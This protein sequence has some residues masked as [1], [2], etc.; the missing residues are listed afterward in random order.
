MPYET[1]S[2]LVSYAFP[3]YACEILCSGND[4]IFKI[5][6]EN[7]KDDYLEFA[8]IDMEEEMDDNCSSSADEDSFINVSAVDKEITFEYQILETFLDFLLE[9]NKISHNNNV[10]CGYFSKV[11]VIL[12][13]KNETIMMNMLFQNKGIY[14]KSLVEL[15]KDK[16]IISCLRTLLVAKQFTQ[17]TIKRK[18]KIC[19]ML[20]N[21]LYNEEYA[22]L[23]SE[24]IFHNLLIESGTFKDMFIV[25]FFKFSKTFNINKIFLIKPIIK[26]LTS[27]I[28][29]IKT[30]ITSSSDTSSDFN[31][32]FSQSKVKMHIEVNLNK[33]LLVL[34]EHAVSLITFYDKENIS[35]LN[36]I[37]IIEYF[38]NYILL[39]TEINEQKYYS[40]LYPL[41]S[42]KLMISLTNFMIYHPY[43][44]IYHSSYTNYLQALHEIN[45]K[46]KYFNKYLID[47]Q[48]ISIFINYLKDIYP[49]HSVLL[50]P[51]IKCFDIIKDLIIPLHK[52]IEP[53]ISDI[54]P[55]FSQGILYPPEKYENLKEGE[56]YYK[57][58]FKDIISESI[59]KNLKADSFD[60]GDE[61]ISEK[62][63]MNFDD[64]NTNELD[65]A[66]DDIEEVDLIENIIEEG[67]NIK[68]M[69]KMKIIN[70]LIQIYWK[71]TLS[72]MKKMK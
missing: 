42:R 17:K 31:L 13:Q 22:E 23:I 8:E 50:A 37:I 47:E 35:S 55:Y 19:Y 48:L 3:F 9:K 53:F 5:I 4:E 38:T 27:V 25:N 51:V 32:D 29:V 30:S 49:E 65:L 39:I 71:Q 46:D 1:D 21:K 58:K 10:L 63:E 64:N 18:I 2:D 11:F 57:E 26:I 68:N 62:I 6:F 36:T 41:I 24:E 61:N 69:K 43:N 72:N 40:Y 44:N 34:Q 7:P 33:L 54:Y 16:G 59:N 15:C 70:I 20:I 52:E 60:S 56:L 67:I 28:N 66:I 14:I 45:I 12:F